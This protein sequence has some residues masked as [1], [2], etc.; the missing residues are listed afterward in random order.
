M[1]SLRVNVLAAPSKQKIE[2]TF[3]SEEEERCFLREIVNILSDQYVVS[4]LVCDLDTD[5]DIYKNHFGSSP[6]LF[7][8]DEPT[9]PTIACS[10]L[11]PHGIDLA[12]DNWGYYTFDAFL[13]WTE[14]GIAFSEKSK[15]KEG[16]AYVN[17]SILTIRQVLDYSL[18]IHVSGSVLVELWPMFL[19]WINTPELP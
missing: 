15:G 7:F 11:D 3:S 13:Y 4:A 5:I 18:E 19:K 14:R 1:K 2:I 10:I 16:L 6:Y 9:H 17:D 8:N 12:I